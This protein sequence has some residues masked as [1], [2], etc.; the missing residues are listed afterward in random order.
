MSSDSILVF[1]NTLSRS[2][3]QLEEF[4]GVYAITPSTGTLEPETSCKVRVTFSPEDIVLHEVTLPL[5]LDGHKERP[6][7]TVRLA[8]CGVYPRLKFDREEV[9]LPIVPV[10]FESRT[11]FHVLNG[12]YESLQ[13]GYHLPADTEHMPIK[14]EFPEG[15]A[16]GLAKSKVPVVVS[17]TGKSPLAFTGRVDFMMSALA[18]SVRN[19]FVPSTIFHS[20]VRSVV[21]TRSE[22][23]AC[24]GTLL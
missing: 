5:Y 3:L 22:A 4:K 9:I 18:W 17:F 24:A 11:L 14:L 10:G 8:G 12:G 2:S 16:I 21:C 7:L 6:Y 19:C 13:L 20:S 15:M 23:F 1:C